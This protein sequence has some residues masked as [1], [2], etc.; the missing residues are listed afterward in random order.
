MNH[1]HC[2]ATVVAVAVILSATTTSAQNLVANGDFNLDVIG[3]TP[4]A[5]TYGWDSE[6]FQQSPA[7]GSLKATNNGN[8]VTT[9]ALFA[10]VDGIIG[11]ESYDLGGWTWIP[12]GQVGHG[13]VGFGVYWYDSAGC[14]GTSLGTP[15]LIPLIQVADDWTP[16]ARFGLV[17]PPGAQSAQVTLFN[18]KYSSGTD[19]FVAHYDGVFLGAFG[20]IFTDGFETGNADLW[21]SALF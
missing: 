8:G 12:T 15:D 9:S 1:T 10:C 2:L 21:T 13:A 4:F 17:A 14:L 3:W 5:I 11:G 19:P 18:T 20:G 16:L 7:S 6:D